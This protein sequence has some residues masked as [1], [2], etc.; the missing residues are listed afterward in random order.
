MTSDMDQPTKRKRFVVAVH[1]LISGPSEPVGRFRFSV[2]VHKNF[3]RV[4]MYHASRAS[5]LRLLRA[6][7][8]WSV[9][10]SIYL[11]P[12]SC[13]KA[14]ETVK[15]HRYFT[16]A[17]DGLSQPWKAEGDEDIRIAR[18]QGY[19][20]LEELRGLAAR[21][22]HLKQSYSKELHAIEQALGVALGYT[23]YCDDQKNFPAATEADGV[24]VGEHVAATIAMEASERI[25]KLEAEVGQLRQFIA[26]NTS[27]SSD[28]V[29][30][31]KQHL[32]I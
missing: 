19:V 24:C 27:F 2:Y 25:K 6:L 17:D 32:W 14:N 29:D 9:M 15:A 23:R 20:P 31:G 11:D 30:E 10:G 1:L 8:G 16:I 7:E 21:I 12:A 3:G 5:Y 13:A 18:R 26:D 4:K 28:D 22:E